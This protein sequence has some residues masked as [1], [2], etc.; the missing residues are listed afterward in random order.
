[1]AK[2]PSFDHD[3][4]GRGLLILVELDIVELGL[5]G[6]V[7][8]VAGEVKAEGGAELEYAWEGEGKL[9]IGGEE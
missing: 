2:A 8:K 9:L 4:G 3:E 7:E 1:L 6:G 5:Y